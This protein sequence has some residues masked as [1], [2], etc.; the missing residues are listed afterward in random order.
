MPEEIKAQSTPEGTQ[1]SPMPSVEQTES[2]PVATEEVVANRNETP[3]TEPSR[4]QDDFELPQEVS[5]RTREQFNKLRDQLS[6]YKN[7]AGG[8]PQQ[9]STPLYDLDT[10]L[11]NP[12][13]LDNLN[14]TAQLAEERA[15][16]AEAK[17][18]QYLDSLQ[19]KEAYAEFPD[20]DPN[21]RTFNKELHKAVRGYITDSM[22]NP[23]DYGGR[24]ITMAE[25]ARLLTGFSSKKIDNV[26][27]EVAK[28]VLKELTPKEEASLEA[29]GR[30][31]RAPVD[32][33]EIRERSRSGDKLAV[34]QRLKMLSGK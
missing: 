3:V 11:I 2:T 24:E 18:N 15:R 1:V 17:L 10:G 14:R 31:D 25:A 6:Y 4:A 16:V 32:V 13:G 8:L 19:E 22:V 7:Q 12:L 33:D 27:K 21:S 28:E 26:K 5:K 23:M 30:S 9:A 20:L 29:R 34:I